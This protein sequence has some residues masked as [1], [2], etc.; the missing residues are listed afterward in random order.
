MA[1]RARP[2]LRLLYGNTGQFISTE[3]YQLVDKSRVRYHYPCRIASN[4]L[5]YNVHYVPCCRTQVR[6]RVYIKGYHGLP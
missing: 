5:I 3:V 2:Y 1:L 4:L 6:T